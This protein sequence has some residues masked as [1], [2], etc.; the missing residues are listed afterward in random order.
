MFIFT[1][2]VN[3]KN[4]NYAKKIN[5]TRIISAIR[6]IIIIMITLKWSILIIKQRFAL[7]VRFMEN[8]GSYLKTILKGV[9]VQNV[10]SLMEKPR[11]KTI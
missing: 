5:N 9:D 4:N 11:L 8:F 7:Y 10:I 2:K 6:Y 3:L 1:Y